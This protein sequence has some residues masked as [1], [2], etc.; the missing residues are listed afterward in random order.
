M[1]C[2]YCETENSETAT[3]CVACGHKLT[4][5]S[6]VFHV[7]LQNES[8]IID[9]S[10]EIQIISP[11]SSPA[12]SPV[13]TEADLPSV[14]PPVPAFLRDGRYEIKKQLGEGGMGRL[15]LATDNAVDYPV[16]VK[17][18][19]P[20]FINRKQKDYMEK[21]FKE[22]A[23]LLFRLKHSFLPRVTD[24][25][26][27]KGSLYLVMEYIEG[28]DL[29]QQAKQ[30]PNNRLPLDKFLKWI[31]SSL[32]I[33]MYLH[34]QNP[35]VL[36][37]D[38]KP[39]NIMVNRDDEIFLVDFG[40]ARTEG[41]STFTH[42]GTPG[43][44]SLDHYTGRFSPSSDL[45]SLGATFHYMLSG[46][47]P[48][49]RKAFYFPA[50]DSY[51]DDI[52]E[53][54][55]DIFD[56]LLEMN[57]DDR[58]HQA[59]EVV[60][61]LNELLNEL[62]GKKTKKKKKKNTVSFTGKIKPISL[63]SDDEDMPENGGKALKPLKLKPEPPSEEKTDDKKS[64]TAPGSS[65]IPSGEPVFSRWSCIRTMT[66]HA[67]NVLS[68]VYS[69]DGKLIASASWD[70]T[71]RIWNS[72]SGQC[73]KILGDHAD[74]VYSTAFSPD[75]KLVASGSYDKTVKIWDVNTGNCLKTLVGHQSYANYV[76]FSPNGKY[77]ASSGYD[78]V[79]KIWNVETGDCIRTLQGHTLEVWSAVFSPNGKYIASAS[80][81][82]TIKIWQVSSE[83]CLRTFEGHSDWVYS[84][85]FSP[86]GKYIAS[87]GRDKEIRIWGPDK[88][89]SLKTFTGHFGDICSVSFSWD[90]KYLVSASLDKTIKIWDVEDETCLA[91]LAGHTNGVNSAEFYP[92]GQYVVSGSNDKTIKIWGTK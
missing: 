75:G 34:N 64:K 19:L 80:I 66:E 49:N 87:G 59:E 43:F 67:N 15:F 20:I 82:K 38:I 72:T 78:R 57:V 74:W 53:K 13:Q 35:P 39:S 84:V 5:S 51:R 31:V 77:I 56:N 2:P 52:P 24:C 46:D 18:M 42:V 88:K 62:S 23:K 25:F 14:L 45:Y 44:A 60:E 36:H 76:V 40:V 41:T 71:V 4:K 26:S 11:L 70:E 47:D 21:R 16:V 10:S 37:R 32:D 33:L 55:Q 90:G 12:K 69:P 89:T 81:D 86:L 85:S 50:L 8:S 68:V 17:E 27:E 92:T 1:I 79:I 29:E 48:R 30:F 58:Y 3:F 61:D 83:E 6:S 91:T 63:T 7:A 73:L 22:E 28:I 65:S 9:K 54:L